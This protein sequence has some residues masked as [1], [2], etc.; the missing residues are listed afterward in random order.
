MNKGSL[1]KKTK[2]EK[3]ICLK[4]KERMENK[5]EDHQAKRKQ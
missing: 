4:E 3:I 1:V 2:K 5:L